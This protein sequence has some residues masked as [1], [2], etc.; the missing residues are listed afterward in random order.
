M[1]MLVKGVRSSWEA[2]ITNSLF[3]RSSSASRV[4][5]RNKSTTPSREPDL[6]VNGGH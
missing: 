2:V 3:K 6:A 4:T 5:S 1:P